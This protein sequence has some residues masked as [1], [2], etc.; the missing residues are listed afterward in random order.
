MPVTYHCRCGARVRIRAY[1]P[2]GQV[3]CPACGAVR[4]LPKSAPATEG[5]T[6]RGSGKW[7]GVGVAVLALVLLGLAAWH[8]YSQRS[9]LAPTEAQ[10]ASN[11]TTPTPS[12]GEGTQ[13]RS[14]NEGNQSARGDKL[15]G[16][17]A[18]SPQR[19]EE[20][21][22]AGRRFALLVG[23]NDYDHAKLRQLHYAVP[24]AA[25]TATVLRDGGYEVT[26]FTASVGGKNEGER[27]TL[28]NIR[29]ALARM[30]GPRKRHD[31]VLV[32]L[33]GH[34]L[35]LGGG[36][37]NY[38][39]PRDANPVD[40]KTLLPLQE[41]YDQLDRS[42]AGVKLLLVDACRDDPKAG[43]GRG[44]NGDTAPRPPRG[45]AALFSC[46]AGEQSFES[47]KLKH[48]VFFH[49][50]LQGLTGKAK[51]DEGKVTWDGLQQ[52]V[53]TRVARDVGEVIE[54]AQQTP[55]LVAGELSGEPPVL[56]A[57]GGARADQGPP[58]QPAP[59]EDGPKPPPVPGR[60]PFPSPGTWDLMAPGGKLVVLRLTLGADNTYS[61][62]NEEDGVNKYYEVTGNLIYFK[63]HNVGTGRKDDA[64]A[65][66]F[67][68]TADAGVWLFTQLKPE[69]KEYELRYNNSPPPPKK[70][71]AEGGPARVK[72][73]KGKLAGLWEW[74]AKDTTPRRH[75]LVEFLAEGGY[76]QV[77]FLDG[78][79][80]ITLKDLYGD[81][82]WS[83]TLGGDKLRVFRSG[84]SGPPQ[85]YVCGAI[86]WLDGDAFE[87]AVT[88]DDRNRDFSKGKA[89]LFRRR[90]GEPDK[91][92]EGK[93]AGTW[94]VRDGTK[95]IARVVLS[96][97]GTYKGPVIG[98]TPLDGMTFEAVQYIYK[99]GILT[100]EQHAQ[101]KRSFR[102]RR[103]AIEWL[104]KDLFRI[105]LLD[106]IDV[107]E[108]ARNKV[109]ELQRE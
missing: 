19:P 77:T 99:Q 56:L 17:S 24:D 43:R 103:G 107:D 76:D 46:S 27:P 82:N 67:S 22:T 48:G 44:L 87:L 58:P 25:D 52:Y 57:L 50:V 95:P 34:G 38:F 80:G 90:S 93:L 59:A 16:P 62:G 3:R 91:A 60:I 108:A 85:D 74:E 69:K 84:G 64:F 40:A 10:T 68:P 1:R 71:T 75:G 105:E 102:V 15:P 51:N 55:S 14:A 18:D 63:R 35:Q 86:T 26:L 61:D 101:G 42:G 65:G 6:R 104:D 106:G 31:L 8:L 12:A 92:R 9:V 23:I 29:R 32:G 73:E 98:R 28:D 47:D 109:Y 89:Y 37:D 4:L 66:R 11:A 97:D 83:Y 20:G 45:V 53:R 70:A 41:V 94:V 39:C 78:R 30:L 100:L 13:A 49:Y 88:F 7:L 36:K 5:A 72:G 96:P 21:A 54:G 33:A 81:T 2:G 79:F